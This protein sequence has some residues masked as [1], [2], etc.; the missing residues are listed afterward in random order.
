MNTYGCQ[1]ADIN[2]SGVTVFIVGIAD[3]KGG[4]IVNCIFLEFVEVLDSKFF[5]KELESKICCNVKHILKGIFPNSFK[6]LTDLGYLIVK[7]AFKVW[8]FVCNDSD[9]LCD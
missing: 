9:N 3:Y 2:I 5:I 6:I 8:V 4:K 1:F 7:Q